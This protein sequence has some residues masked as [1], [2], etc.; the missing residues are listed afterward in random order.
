MLNDNCTE[1]PQR[2]QLEMLSDRMTYGGGLL[3]LKVF[4]LKLPFGKRF[5]RRTK[6]YPYSPTSKEY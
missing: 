4:S 1:T 3:S 5:K 2:Q 6:A